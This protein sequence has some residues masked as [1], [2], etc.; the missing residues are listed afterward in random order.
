M[1]GPQ[2]QVTKVLYQPLQRWPLLDTE[3]HQKALAWVEDKVDGGGSLRTDYWQQGWSDAVWNKKAENLRLEFPGGGPGF[4]AGDL[5]DVKDELAKEIRWLISVRSYF[6]RLGAPYSDGALASLAELQKIAGKVQDGVQP[7][8]TP[9]PRCRG[10]PSPPRWGIRGH[11][12]RLHPVHGCVPGARDVVSV[13]KTGIALVRATT[14]APV[15]DADYRAK[16]A[17]LGVTLANNIQRSKDALKRMQA[18]V[19]GDYG[20]LKKLGELGD[21][22]QTSPRCPHEWSLPASAESFARSLMI[23]QTKQSFYSALLP[24]KFEADRLPS[25]TGGLDPSARD[26]WCGIYQAGG[27]YRKS[28]SFKNEPNSGFVQ[29]RYLQPSANPPTRWL[30]LAL[31]LPERIQPPFYFPVFQGAQ[32]LLARPAVRASR[33][34]Q[35]DRRQPRPDQNRVLPTDLGPGQRSGLLL[36]ESEIV[37]AVV[38]RPRALTSARVCRFGAGHP[39]LAEPWNSFEEDASR[40]GSSAGDDLPNRSAD[41]GDCHDRGGAR[42][43][44][45]VRCRSDHKR[46]RAPA[47]V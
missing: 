14:G 44:G 45:P 34:R 33:P 38:A 10:F 28:F 3:A 4:E 20:K 18:I 12:R 6:A 36:H 47:K 32:G 42:R 21:C 16:V 22:S 31:R 35:P 23:L 2:N 26:W 11:G 43:G 25:P 30:T 29:L 17:D 40:R 39:R 1:S 9:R 24:L 46:S 37:E 19:V 27:R 13:L 8:R 41:A 5:T 7:R 15:S